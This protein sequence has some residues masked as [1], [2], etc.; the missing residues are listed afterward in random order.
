MELF[1]AWVVFFIGLGMLLTGLFSLSPFQCVRR[2][3]HGDIRRLAVVM[4]IRIR[5]DNARA[6]LNEKKRGPYYHY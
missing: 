3:D 1:F 6:K 4:V 5:R 2:N